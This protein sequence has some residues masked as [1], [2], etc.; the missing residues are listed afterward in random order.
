MISSVKYNDHA[1][2]EPE[3]PKC[4][5]LIFLSVQFSLPIIWSK[6]FERNFEK[7]QFI[8]AFTKLLMWQEVNMGNATLIRF[9]I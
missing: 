4:I 2:E 8:D 1:L 5:C 9:F 3:S 6:Q 7:D